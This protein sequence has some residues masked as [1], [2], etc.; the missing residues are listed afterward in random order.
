MALASKQSE[1]IHGKTGGDKAKLQA[2]YDEGH[3][4]TLIDLADD[5]R[6]EYGA[7]LIQIEKMQDDIDELRRYI[8][9]NELLVT[10]SGSALPTRAS[11]TS[12]VLWNNRG[13]VTVS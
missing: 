7:L 13:I 9:S 1:T 3:L 6:P 2:N 5:G 11:K 8:I 10:A 4:N 12:G